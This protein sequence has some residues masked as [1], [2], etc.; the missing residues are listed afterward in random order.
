VLTGAGAFRL[1]RREIKEE[2]H[3]VRVAITPF[4]QAESD[5]RYI[6]REDEF[7]AWEKET[8][9]DVKGYKAG[10]SVYNSEKRWQP[11]ATD[12]MPRTA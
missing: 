8:M 6:L 7:K 3:L 4:L 12:S 10:E 5:Y 11:P 2:K 1:F 9:K